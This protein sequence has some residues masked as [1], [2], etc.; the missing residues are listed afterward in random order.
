M[1]DVA[2]DEVVGFVVGLF[3]VGGGGGWGGRLARV[4]KER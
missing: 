1:V 3:G 4:R 2:V